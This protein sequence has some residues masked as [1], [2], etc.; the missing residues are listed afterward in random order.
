M[1]DTFPAG[2]DQA[3]APLP[4]PLLPSHP[5]K[6]TKTVDLLPGNGSFAGSVIPQLTPAVP[7][8]QGLPRPS[9]GPEPQPWFTAEGN[10]KD[11]MGFLASGSS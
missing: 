2:V 4:L 3:R 10:V 8:K 7:G 11:S 9:G 6:A 1:G 5:V